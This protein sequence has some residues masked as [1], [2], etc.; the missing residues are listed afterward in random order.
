M[1]AD[2]AMLDWH[3]RPLLAHMRDLAGAVAAEVRIVGSR[4][5]FGAYGDVLED[6]YPG[7]GPLA[8]IQAALAASTPASGPWARR[9]PNSTTR[10][11]CAA[12]MIREI[13]RAHV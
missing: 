7:C 5:K 1:A 9:D 12:E 8:G 3:G 13:G 2:K 6:V 11:P 4:A 10:R